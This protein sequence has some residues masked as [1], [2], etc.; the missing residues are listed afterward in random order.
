[1][2]MDWLP[3]IFFDNYLLVDQLIKQL[4]HPL[5]TAEDKTT[6][7]A[8]VDAYTASEDPSAE[9]QAK[10]AT[11]TWGWNWTCLGHKDTGV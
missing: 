9:W 7:S 11:S 4:A 3:C 10:P 6:V 2:S 8:S 5:G 1:M